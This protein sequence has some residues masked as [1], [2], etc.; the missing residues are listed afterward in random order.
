[1]EITKEEGEDAAA[2]YGFNVMANYVMLSMK[3]AATNII[4]EKKLKEKENE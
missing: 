4:L 1:M 3:L 2:S